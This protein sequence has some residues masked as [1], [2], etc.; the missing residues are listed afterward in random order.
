MKNFLMGIL[1]STMVFL[2]P[3]TAQS[4]TI[5]L[6]EDWQL[7]LSNDGNNIGTIVA[8][9]MLI[10]GVT[11]DNS[12]PYPEING[13]SP[14]GDFEILSTFYTS[15][16]Q[17]N[18]TPTEDFDINS[19]Y[20]LTLV[21]TGVGNYV[22]KLDAPNDLYFTSTT[23]EFFVDTSID[24]G[25]TTDFYGADNGIKIAE[26]ELFDGS[27]TM[28]FRDYPD[29]TAD[30]NGSTDI[31]LI[32]TFLEEGYWLDESGNDMS[33]YQENTTLV[34][35]ITDMNN[36]FKDNPN[37]TQISEFTAEGLTY[38]ED[39]IFDFFVTNDG[40]FGI[41]TAIV[42][43]PA[44]FLMFGTGLLCLSAISRKKIYNI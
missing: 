10:K 44:T 43:E 31:T 12:S 14:G 36:D 37:S 30:V 38:T 26:F 35:G 8:D 29:S 13:V 18:D 25:S 41:G 19:D 21:L 34:F 20:E 24:Y 40:S 17:N 42:P 16:F 39:N 5:N 28:D 33:L 27:G 15:G 23:L 11:L 22:S 32:S 7:N 4:F 6:M 2:L 1:V 9:E 3:L